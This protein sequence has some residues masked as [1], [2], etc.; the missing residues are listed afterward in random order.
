[1]IDH[2]TRAADAGLFCLR[3]SAASGLGNG[4]PFEMVVGVGSSAGMRIARCN[5]TR[6]ISVTPNKGLAVSARHLLSNKVGSR[7]TLFAN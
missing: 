4:V 3:A 7:D 5:S 1:M 2:A 6:A